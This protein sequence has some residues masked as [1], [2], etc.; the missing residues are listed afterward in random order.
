MAENEDVRR[1]ILDRELALK[2]NLARLHNQS[3][4]ELWN[5]ASGTYRIDYRWGTTQT[6]VGDILRGL[7]EGEVDA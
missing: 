3:A 5:E 2:G 4:L 7:E 6:I 1:L